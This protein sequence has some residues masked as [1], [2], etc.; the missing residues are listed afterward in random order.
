MLANE[1]ASL[2][3]SRERREGLGAQARMLVESMSWERV[4]QQ[5]WNVL[6]TAV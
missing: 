3:Q 1:L 2:C 6:G 4:A 5:Y